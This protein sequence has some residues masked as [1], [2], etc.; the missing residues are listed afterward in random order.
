MPAK[1]TRVKILSH[2]KLSDVIYKMVV[3]HGGNKPAPGQFYMLRG[4]EGFPLLGR[5]ISVNDADETNVTF[6]YE[7]LGQ[8]T[9]IFSKMSVGEEIEITGPLGNNFD[10]SLTG[11]IALVSGGVGYAPMV[12]VAKM[13]KGA[14]VDLYCGFS[15]TSYALEDIRPYVNNIFL[16]TDSGKEGH[17]GFATELL[18]V[19]KYDYVL[20]CGPEVMMM[21]L[22][23]MCR[24]TNTK[25]FVSLDRHMA[26]GVGA[27]LGCTCHTLHGAKCVCKDG[28]VF[29]GE[30]VVIDA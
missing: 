8:G 19:N 16:A 12:Y 9:K 21:S 7:V 6:L 13:L 18:D 25:C 17:H 1:T 14:Q 3:P 30:E 27:C 20:T 5:P 23:K 2:Q 11:K 10:T 24:G 28:P 26:C 4:L 15:D 29:A 22:A